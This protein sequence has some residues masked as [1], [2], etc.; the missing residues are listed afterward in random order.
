MGEVPLH[1]I[2][3][4]LWKALRC[5]EYRGVKVRPGIFFLF[6]SNL[7]K[8]DQLLATHRSPSTGNWD[9]LQTSCDRPRLAHRSSG[10]HRRYTERVLY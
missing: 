3:D 2:H 4:P 9:P 5:L 1:L 6:F 7:L 8:S 10:A